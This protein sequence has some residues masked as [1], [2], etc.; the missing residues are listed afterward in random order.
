[1]ALQL[2]DATMGA[3]VEEKTKI[4]LWEEFLRLS[5]QCW[6][7]CCFLVSVLSRYTRRIAIPL[8]TGNGWKIA[9]METININ[10]KSCIYP[11]AMLYDLIGLMMLLLLNE[12]DGS[13]SWGSL[14][15]PEIL[16]SPVLESRRQ[17]EHESKART[18]YMKAILYNLYL[19][20]RDGERTVPF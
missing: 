4:W 2:D 14:W 5:T 8:S 7:G 20:L 3:A 10:I 12:V 17:H 19:F 6:Q 11:C 1:M 13:R 15:L 16:R 9:S 18:S